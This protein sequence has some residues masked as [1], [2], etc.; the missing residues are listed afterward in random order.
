MVLE[1]PGGVA[2]D[3]LSTVWNRNGVAVKPFAH[4]Y[5][6]IVMVLEASCGCCESIIDGP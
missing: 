2:V 6:G 3:P 4:V 5:N 1:A